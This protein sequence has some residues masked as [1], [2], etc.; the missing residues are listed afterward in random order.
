MS[1]RK[2]KLLVA[3]FVALLLASGLS[4][5][6]LVGQS[7][8]AA[9]AQTGEQLTAATTQAATTAAVNWVVDAVRTVLIR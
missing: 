2:P 5:G 1:A 3:A 9:A 8:R 4:F 7:H 6:Y